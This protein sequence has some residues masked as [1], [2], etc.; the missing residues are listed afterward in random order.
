MEE[1]TQHRTTMLRRMARRRLA[2]LQNIALALLLLLFWAPFHLPLIFLCT[3]TLIAF[4]F[5]LSIP[6][7][8]IDLRFLKQSVSLILLSLLLWISIAYTTYKDYAFDYC[9]KQTV[10]LLVPL[11]FCGMTP[12]FFSAKRL[13]FFAGCFVAGCVLLLLVKV[14]QLVY[15]FNIFLPYFTI[16]Y[17]DAGIT[18]MSTGSGFLYALNEFL[19]NQ[20]IYLSWAFLQPI[21]HTITEGL[22]FNMAFTLL[23]VARIQKHPFL[24]SRL[25]KFLA[26]FILFLFTLALVTSCS[27]T[28]QILF[29][30]NLFLLLLFAFRKKRWI[31]ACGLSAFLLLAG[32]VGFH[33]LGMGILGRF[34][35][36][37]QVAENIKQNKE[38]VNDGSLLPR[39][40]SWSSALDMAKEKP[41]FGFG[42]GFLKEYKDLFDSRYP[43]FQK[44]YWHPHNQFLIALLS[45][46]IIGLLVFLLFL[47]QTVRIVWKSRLLWGWIWLL[48]LLLLCSID[49][50]FYQTARFYCCLPYCFL[51]AACYNRSLQKR[52]SLQA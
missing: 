44:N 42:S 2:L 22:V 13:D 8:A 7:R 32:A 5:A 21:M 48:G 41:V 27:K 12:R 19:S 50:I 52:Q 23:F 39:V 18:Y 1:I 43:E 3:G 47:V 26:D 16:R 9:L 30:V 6:R 33:Y 40:Y 49:T 51:M 10:F 28:G 36:S 34:K 20:V 31:L 45:G 25:R 17:I 24:K 14:L 35:K 4:A 46:G 15:C 38:A 37:I 11:L 29:G